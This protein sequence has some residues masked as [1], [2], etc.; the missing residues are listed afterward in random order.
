MTAQSIPILI[1]AGITFYSGLYHL[2]IYFRQRYRLKD[3]A[4]A[5]LCLGVLLYDIFAAMIYN[6][7]SPFDSLK[8][9]RLIYI[10]T[11]L[12]TIGF[13]WFVLLYTENKA[14]KP[15]YI[16]SILCVIMALIQIID[17]SSLTFTDNPLI[18]EFTLFSSWKIKYNEIE[19]GLITNIESTITFLAYLYIIGISINNHLKGD[20]RKAAPLLLA[21][22][23]FMVAL[24]N[25]ISVAVGLYKFIY[26]VEYAFFALIII[27]AF[28]LSDEVLRASIVEEE[29]KKS[30]AK[31]RALTEYTPIVTLILSDDLIYKYVSPSI[32]LILGYKPEEITGRKPD[33]LVHP[34][35]V[36]RV[37]EAMQE[38]RKESGSTR[39]VSGYR[40]KHKNGQ[41]RHFE[42]IFTNMMDVPGVKG[43][44]VNSR[45]VTDRIIAEDEL[46]FMRFSVEN[47]TIPV[48]WMGFDARFTYVNKAACE[49][50]GY[51]FDEL[52]R[53]SVPD[54][55]PLF[56]AEIW[57][58]HW[59]EIKEKISF[60]FESQHRR[61]NGTIY[62]VQITVNYLEY[63]DKEYNFAIAIDITERKKAEEELAEYREHLEEIIR[64]RSEE[65]KKAQKSLV[66]Q[67]K[68]A[69][70]GHLVAVVSHELRNPLGTINNSLQTIRERCKNGS[71]EIEPA[72]NR[73]ERGIA[74]CVDIIE[75]LLYFTR[76][77]EP[78]FVST[79]IDQWISNIIDDIQFPDNVKT[80]R[81]LNTGLKLEIDNERCR[82]C[83]INLATNA[84]H[85]INE[86]MAKHPDISGK[87][88]S[89]HFRT[90]IANDQLVISVID[91]GT[92][93][94]QE[95]LEKIF[96]PLYSTK[97]FGVGLGLS[98]VKQ[99]MD[100]HKGNI[101]F[102]S[103][104]GVGTT[105]KIIIPL[106]K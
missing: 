26:I 24:L 1:I 11:A 4:F 31:F 53:M 16:F 68:L 70:L 95:E 5:I 69:T 32:E 82:R 50:L 98:I 48:F 7:E 13:L 18:K 2:I 85:A 20:K 94:S 42:G 15:F 44:V 35:C 46:R 87:E 9:Q 14:R 39:R 106:N 61:K 54:I 8:W 25:D 45:D 27:M 76:A 83:I 49:S 29:L 97:S 23:I 65:L 60:N 47:A 10:N 17:R 21:L 92:G 36:I 80:I 100:E 88:H 96:E 58:D 90:E 75:E 51:A 102:E 52:I 64:V 86:D 43:I 77:R 67:E 78:E 33:D 6:S 105:A 73:A 34:E 63:G 71:V 66:K 22:F 72:L 3:L 12:T 81:E 59:K 74:R 57:P 62:P 99:I 91:T 101:E 41:W 38:L 28:A 84:I 79:D 30:E 37:K 93:I 89:I 56:P 104:Y 19:H 40:V 103:E 55:D